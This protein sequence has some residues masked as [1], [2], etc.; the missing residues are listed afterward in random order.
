[1]TREQAR[2]LTERAHQLDELTKHPG[3]AVLVDWTR[4][5]PAGAA[6][7]QRGLLAGNAKSLEDYQYEVGWLAGAEH[8]LDAPQRVRDM[9]LAAEQAIREASEADRA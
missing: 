4:H 2:E 1:V 9:A 6:N 8:V 5:G 7:R 3:W